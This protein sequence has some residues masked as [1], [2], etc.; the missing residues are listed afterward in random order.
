LEQIDLLFSGPRVLIDMPESELVKLQEQEIQI[1]LAE[2]RIELTEGK[3][4]PQIVYV[5]TV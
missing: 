2:H 5:E 3:A 1:A 4:S